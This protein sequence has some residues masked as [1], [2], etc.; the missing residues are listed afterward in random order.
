VNPARDPGGSLAAPLRQATA[1]DAAALAELINLA[2]H[3]M[4]EFLW[5]R[6]AGPGESPRAVGERRAA[7]D[8][9]SF[10]WRNAI[11]YEQAGA[12]V[13]CLIG[14]A[15]PAQAEPLPPDLPAM[16]VPLQELENLVPGS[17][18][19]NAIACLPGVRGQ[20]IGSRLMAL[21]DQLAVDSGCREVSLIVSDANQGAVRL[22]RRLGFA[23]LE[24]RPMVH[25]GWDNPGRNWLLMARP[26]PPGRP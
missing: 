15:L 1:G 12:V 6:M 16:F 9:G 26:V 21:A 24:R 8:E 20:G 4:P 11:V 5:A 18:Y 14:Y 3:G 23:E 10:S 25:D 2:G 17:W 22:Y 7:R 19:I 13:A